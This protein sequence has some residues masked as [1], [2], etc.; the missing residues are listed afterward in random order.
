MT[1]V[2]GSDFDIDVH[3]VQPWDAHALV[4]TSYADWRCF[5]VGDSAPSV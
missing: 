2:V 4:A 3:S 1:S 5:L